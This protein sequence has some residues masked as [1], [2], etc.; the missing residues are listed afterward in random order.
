MTVHEHLIPGLGIRIAAHVGQAASN[1]PA[2]I[3]GCWHTRVHLVGRQRPDVAYTA[4]RCAVRTVVPDGLALES[5]ILGH[6]AGSAARQDEGVRSREVGMRL[7]IE[8]LA[9]LWN[10]ARAVV[11]RG[12][13]NSDSQGRSGLE[14]LV[15]R[16]E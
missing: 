1:A 4:A 12:S 2:G 11:A 13:A 6:D 7:T 16:L 14:R 15:E 3:R 10:V 8:H 9:L 5:A